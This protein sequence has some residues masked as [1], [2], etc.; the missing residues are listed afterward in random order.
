MKEKSLLK[1]YRGR[2]QMQQCDQDNKKEQGLA[3]YVIWKSDTK[4]MA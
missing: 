4:L 2:G 3:G 1:I